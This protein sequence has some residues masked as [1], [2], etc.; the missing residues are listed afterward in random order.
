MK[1]GPAYLF[2]EDTEF[3][4]TQL[5]ETLLELTWMH[6]P[7]T[8]VLQYIFTITGPNNEVI[9]RT[10]EAGTAAETFTQLFENLDAATEYMIVVEYTRDGDVT[11]QPLTGPDTFYTRKIPYQNGDVQL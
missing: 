2:A 10:V 8:G 6:N 5:T 1:R 3:Q 11:P 7:D 4:I 9:T